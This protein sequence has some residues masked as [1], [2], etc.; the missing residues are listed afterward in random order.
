MSYE[1]Q[2]QVISRQTVLSVRETTSIQE[3]PQRL[4][5]IY[6]EIAQYLGQLGISPEG[7][8]FV[9]YYNLDMENLQIEAGI[10]I[11]YEVPNKGDIRF[12]EIMG[13]EAATCLHTGPYTQLERAYN[14]L[15]EWITAQGYETTGVAY[16]FYLNEPDQVPPEELMT[17]IVLPLKDQ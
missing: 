11:G 15:T 17:R 8:P 1:C 7:A 14:A 3:L 12:S 10:P 16:E 2:K 6:G 13:V 4:G 9:A 5:A